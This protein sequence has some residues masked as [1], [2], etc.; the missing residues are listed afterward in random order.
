[1]HLSPF[2]GDC[3]DHTI[4]RPTVGR[5]ALLALGLFALARADDPP[6]DLPAAPAG[7][8]VRR[9][10][11]DRG[12]VET[13]EYDSKSV[14]AKRKMV[15]YTPP[16]Y[17]RDA[18]YPVL[19]LLHGAGDDESGWTRKGS[20]DAILDNL[21]ADK[22]LA[23]MIVVMP[24]GFVAPPGPGAVLAAS[25][26]KRADADKDGKLTEEELTAF[27]KELFKE[28]DKDGKG[29]VDERQLAEALNRLAP[30]PAN[31]FGP[32]QNNGFE[33]DLLKDVIP[34][35]EAHYPVQ[36]DADHRA[37]AGLSMGGGQALGIGLKHLDTFAYVGG[38]SSALFGRSGGLIENPADAAKR[39]RLLWLSCGD[40]DQLMTASKAFHDS[41]DETKVPH[42]WHVD[43][44]RT[45][46]RSGRTIC[47]CWRRCCSG[48]SKGATRFSE[49][50]TQR[51]G[52]SGLRARSAYS[53]ALRARLGRI[54]PER[55]AMNLLNPAPPNRTATSAAAPRLN[56]LPRR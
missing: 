28:C 18:K 15:V 37:I 47:I 40:K 9:D 22:K 39:L 4:C 43:S 24:N 3:H 17:S 51:S 11:I 53:A 25:V 52:V 35:V 20:A 1:M 44:G 14:G 27:A 38:F 26:M 54:G 48:T 13:V 8:D 29:A 49:P 31:P 41:L 36:A 50:R 46:G 45:S 34:Y 7:F 42:V 55:D 33:N 10:G 23:P 5:G 16:G 30:P 56:S 12:K 19:Y 32:R 21:Y 6:K 2:L